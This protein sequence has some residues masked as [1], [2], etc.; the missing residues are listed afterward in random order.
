M[1]SRGCVCTDT[2]IC[3]SLYVCSVPPTPAGPRRLKRKCRRA[4]HWAQR[5]RC[6]GGEDHG[7]GRGFSMG[8]SLDLPK[9]RNQ[10]ASGGRRRD[11]QQ[12][13]WQPA[14]TRAAPGPPAQAAGCLLRRV[15]GYQVREGASTTRLLERTIAASTFRNKLRQQA[16]PVSSSTKLI[17]PLHS[18]YWHCY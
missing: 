7:F 5:A 8:R 17:P 10:T 3:I 18:L 2:D 11:R 12:Q 1:D 14:S 13:L 9:M 6:G 4:T 15:S 16:P